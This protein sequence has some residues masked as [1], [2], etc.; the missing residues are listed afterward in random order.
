MHST[1]ANEACGAG[2]FGPVLFMFV[3]VLSP[4]E[5]EVVADRALASF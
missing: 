2:A 4:S 1:D 3:P 5:R